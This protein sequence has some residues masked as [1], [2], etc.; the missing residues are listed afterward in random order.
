MVGAY[1][2]FIRTPSYE[3]AIRGLLSE[4]DEREEIENRL[5]ANPRAGDVLAGTGGFR[6]LRVALRRRG[7]RGSARVV[8]YLVGS[9]NRIYLVEFFEKNVKANLTPTERRALKTLA[10]VLRNE[11]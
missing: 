5:I 1:W 8:Y 10:R 4:E 11:V 6:K 9:L 2:E 3:T 7:R